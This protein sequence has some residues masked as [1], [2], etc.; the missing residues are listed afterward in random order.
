MGEK[1]GTGK[2][3]KKH[4]ERWKK[5]KYFKVLYAFL[6]SYKSMVIYEN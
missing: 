2:K 4:R 3:K 1:R 6:G 5:Q